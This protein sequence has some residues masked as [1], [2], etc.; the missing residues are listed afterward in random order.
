MSYTVDIDCCVIRVY[1]I[2]TIIL[3]QLSYWDV[4]AGKC[5]ATNTPVIGMERQ[6]RKKYSFFL[7][8]PCKEVRPT[9]SCTTALLWLSFSTAPFQ[10]PNPSSFY[11]PVSFSHLS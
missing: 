7:I 8:V 11:S 3:S 6:S 4:D 1:V 10:L 2:L 5:R 9:S